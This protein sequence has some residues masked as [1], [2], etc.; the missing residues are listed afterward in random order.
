MIAIAILFV[1]MMCD[2]FKSRRQ[3]EAENPGPAAS[4][5]CFTAAR[6]TSIVF[7]LG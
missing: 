5:Q 1:R 2:C 3:L 4:A 6:A 7:A